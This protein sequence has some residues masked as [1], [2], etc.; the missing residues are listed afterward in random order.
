[1][2]QDGLDVQFVCQIV[3]SCKKNKV[4]ASDYQITT[5]SMWGLVASYYQ[6]KSPAKIKDKVMYLSVLGFLESSTKGLRLTKLALDIAEK[7]NN[8]LEQ[9]RMLYE[10]KKES[11][12]SKLKGA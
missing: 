7:Q 12:K 8:I 4:C 5:Q 10:A 2:S 1:M 11:A 6:I 3:N 9:K